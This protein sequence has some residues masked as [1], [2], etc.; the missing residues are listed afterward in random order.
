MREEKN[1]G[2]RTWQMDVKKD[3]VRISNSIKWSTRGLKGEMERT[4]KKKKGIVSTFIVLRE[5]YRLKRTN[6]ASKKIRAPQ[7]LVS[8][9]N[10]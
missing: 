6:M 4:K 1:A 9:Y 5:A 10:Y 8:F 2:R 7:L 3:S